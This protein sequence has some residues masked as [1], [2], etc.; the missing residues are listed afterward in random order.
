MECTESAKMGNFVISLIYSQKF[1]KKSKTDKVDDQDVTLAEA[2][3]RVY[4]KR[5]T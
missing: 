2:K 3:A 1:F 5:H 4:G